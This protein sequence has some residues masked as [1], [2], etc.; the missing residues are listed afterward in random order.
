MVAE[1]PKYP[2]PKAQSAIFPAPT[3]IEPEDIAVDCALVFVAA[4]HDAT[5]V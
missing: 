3:V 4:E 2:A 5:P 1:T